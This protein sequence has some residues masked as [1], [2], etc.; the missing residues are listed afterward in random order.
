MWYFAYGSNMDEERVRVARK[1]PFS[2]RI[3]GKLH[4]YRLLFNKQ[5][6]GNTCEG[7]GNIERAS[8]QEDSVVEGVL[9]L[10]NAEGIAILDKYEGYP[11]HYTRVELEIEQPDSTVVSAITYIALKKGKGLK[12][13]RKYLG[14]LLK[15]RD[16][17]STEYYFKLSET[18]TLD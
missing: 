4:G 8:S 14:H 3:A 18:E 12:P 11:D 6:S 1:I 17:I 10:T 9:Y 13:T 2:R 15:G 16:L 5:S 7:F